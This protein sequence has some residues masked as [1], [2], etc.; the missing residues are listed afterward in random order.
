MGLRM[1]NMAKS[2][3][4][5]EGNQKYC[6]FI[7]L[8]YSETWRCSAQMCSFG[9]LWREKGLIIAV[10]FLIGISGQRSSENRFPIGTKAPPVHLKYQFLE[11]T[12]TE[13]SYFIF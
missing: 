8:G 3:W 7:S 4:F 9:L 2:D 10:L 6:I 12:T 1:P 5:P 13:K 11:N